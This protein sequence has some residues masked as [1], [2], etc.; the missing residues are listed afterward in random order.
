MTNRKAARLA[1]LAQ[2]VDEL[3][4]ALSTLVLRCLKGEQ[5]VT[6]L[7]RLPKSPEQTKKNAIAAGQVVDLMLERDTAAANL[8][9]HLD[10]IA[11]LREGACVNCDGTGKTARRK[12]PYG[13]ETCPD[14]HGSGRE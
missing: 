11:K 12:A 6:G 5:Y 2:N 10:L 4:N 8:R 9:E 7:L 14:C 3:T 13:S 1:H